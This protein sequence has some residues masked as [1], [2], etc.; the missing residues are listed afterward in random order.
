MATRKEVFALA[1]EHLRGT[2]LTGKGVTLQSIRLLLRE[3]GIFSSE[4]VNDS[5][6]Y[7]KP[8]SGDKERQFFID[9][10]VTWKPEEIEAYLVKQPRFDREA[11]RQAYDSLTSRFQ[12]SQSS[13][14]SGEITETLLTLQHHIGWDQC[15]SNFLYYAS[16]GGNLEVLEEILTKA[17]NLSNQAFEKA[18]EISINHDGLEEVTKRLLEHGIKPKIDDL[19]IAVR[20][21]SLGLVKDLFEAYEGSLDDYQEDLFKGATKEVREF[22][23]SKFTN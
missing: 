22:L 13:L 12:K 14:I 8:R 16:H 2:K 9:T 21:A 4:E 19:L 3:K 11:L 1:K 6:D 17:T 23:E 15:V 10:V 20:Y 5:G 18:L 7:Q